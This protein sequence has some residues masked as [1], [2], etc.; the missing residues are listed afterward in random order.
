MAFPV[1]KQQ[2]PLQKLP[3]SKK[4][5]SWRKK[6]IDAG[7]TLA[8]YNSDNRMRDTKYGMRA[9][10]R[11]FDGILDS[12]DIERTVNPWGLDSQT[13]P[14]EMQCYPI[15]TSK[16]N[17]LVGEES[18]RRFDWRLRVTND[19]AVSE[20]EKFVKETILQRLTELAMRE[21]VS[22]EEVQ[23]EVAEIERWKNYEAQ[24]IRERLGTQILNHLW[25]E[26]KLKLV[27]NQGF[28]DALIAGEEIYCADIIGGK[29]IL[30]KVNPLTIYVIG[31]AGSPYI[32]DADIIVEDAYHSIGWVI[33]TY[34]DY[35]TPEMIDS[36]EKG[37]GLM[38]HGRPLIDYPNTSIPYFPFGSDSDGLID[39]TDTGYGNASFDTEGN[40]RVT[41]VV[42]K[43]RR[44][45]GILTYLDPDSGDELETIVDENYKITKSLGE[46]IKWVW[47]NEWWEGT[48]IGKDIYV[49][50]QPRPIQFRRMDNLSIC[51]SG[52]VGTIYNTNSGKAKSLMSMMKPYAYMYN[53]L[54]YRVDKAIAKY[55]GPMIEMDLAK[56]P[57]DW[58][59]DKWLYFGEEMGYLFIDSFSEGN[60]GKATGKLAG[61]F[62]TT[63]KI[64]NPDLGNY[65]A[66]NLEMM[67]Y[68]EDSLGSTVGITRQR[69]GAIDN[70]ETVGG[71]ERSVTQSSHTTEELFL[72]HDYT[73]LRAIEALLETAKYAYMN[74]S[75]V[76]QYMMESDLAQQI[77]NIDG[78]LFSE[79]D[80]GLVM[81]DASMQTELKNALVQLAH[82]GIQAGNLNFS[83]FMDVYMTQSI[84]DTRRKIERAEM[85][86]IQRQQEAEEAQRKHEETMLEM[87][88]ENREDVQ[89]HQMEIEQLKSDT[90]IEV[91]LL[92][93]EARQVEKQMDI[94]NTTDKTPED[95]SF[96]REKF[97]AEYSLKEKELAEKKRQALVKEKQKDEEIIIKRKVAN[98]PKPAKK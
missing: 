65:I 54:A 42:W 10:Y 22:Q 17:L 9:N 28:K 16:I 92:E 44:K 59:L 57:A 56:K 53:K 60:K 96:D 88:I 64:Y 23:R 26:Q 50:M 75:K 19:D 69:E 79:A 21:G 66:Q 18:K 15:A 91:K 29:P 40:V 70:R 27:F 39:V 33:D 35:L 20:K 38:P 82:A 84:A 46:K 83:T 68:I 94:E 14:A 95:N 77:Y 37:T 25:A 3:T 2:W 89:A 49:K 34:Y 11:L 6:C 8:L 63:G 73:K 98:K 78:E 55:K 31:M 32:E 13:F 67:R 43:S 62:N 58:D 1:V 24:D 36:L 5:E 61:E 71:V 87:E 4:D 12:A 85:D 81:T 74:D 45:I 41:R 80:Y 97:L 86:N 47:I 7:L 90:A 76:A 93:I 51:G 52:Y 48:K 30:R 72:V